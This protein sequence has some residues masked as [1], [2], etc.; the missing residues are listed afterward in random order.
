MLFANSESLIIAMAQEIVAVRS[1]TGGAH[2]A[3]TPSAPAAG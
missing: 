2:L 1:K 3:L